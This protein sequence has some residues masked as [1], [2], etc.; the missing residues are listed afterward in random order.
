[1]LRIAVIDT[2]IGIAPEAQEAVFERFVPGLALDGVQLQQGP[3]WGS[4]SPAR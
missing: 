3:A 1:M 4:I 2:G